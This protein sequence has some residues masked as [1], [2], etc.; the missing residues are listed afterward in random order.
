MELQLVGELWINPNCYPI[1]ALKTI[2]L[3]VPD[4]LGGKNPN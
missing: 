2:L 3:L 1:G 4:I